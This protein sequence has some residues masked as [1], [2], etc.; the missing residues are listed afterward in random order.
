MCRAAITI[1]AVACCACRQTCRGNRA[2]S[3]NLPLTVFLYTVFQH[4]VAVQNLRPEEFLIYKIKTGTQI[5][6]EFKPMW[7][8]IRI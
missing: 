5:K 1:S 6:A 4:F 3:P 7:K 2:S 8:K